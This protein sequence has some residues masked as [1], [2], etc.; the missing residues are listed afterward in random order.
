MGLVDAGKL[1][2]ACVEAGIGPGEVEV[3]GVDAVM[4]LE[5]GPDFSGERAEAVLA[6]VQDDGRRG[7]V[8]VEAH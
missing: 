2:P 8:R 7:E 3:K 5:L 4:V 6:G 1:E